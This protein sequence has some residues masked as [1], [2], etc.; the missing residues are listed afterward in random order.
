MKKVLVLT[1]LAS[2]AF[3]VSAKDLNKSEISKKF[4]SLTP[5]TVQGVEDSPSKNLYQVITDK[6]V[7]YVSKD[8]EFIISG[9]LHKME[10]GLTNLTA[11]RMELLYGERIQSLRDSFITYKA[12]NE[13]HEIVVFYDTSC[14]FCQKLHSDISQY[15]AAGITVHYAAYPRSG[16]TNHRGGGF[17]SSYLEMQ[18]IWCSDNPAMVMNMVARGATVPQKSCDNKI[19][20]HYALG[21][22][23]GVQGTPAVYSMSGKIVVPGYASAK[24]VKDKLVEMGL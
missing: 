11:A 3:G 7:F 22:Q 23:M 10:Q 24:S 15:N 1:A 13:Q 6:G 8:G 16:I 2:V 19:A 12:P 4:Q 17:S 21:V 20:E 18:S 9:A 14:G 5:F